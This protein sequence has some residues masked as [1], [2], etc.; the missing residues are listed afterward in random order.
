MRLLELVKVKVNSLKRGSLGVL[1]GGTFSLKAECR[2]VMF[3][4]EWDT[5]RGVAGRE[6][7]CRENDV[8]PAE[9]RTKEFLVSVNARYVEALL[10]CNAVENF[11]DVK[12]LEG[13]EQK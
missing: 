13:F 11:V 6:E 5:S 2:S 12:I 4:N 7:S 3:V 1:R 9:K 10:D 8:R